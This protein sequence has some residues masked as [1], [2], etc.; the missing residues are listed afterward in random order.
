MKNLKIFK[1]NHKLLKRIG[2]ITLLSFVALLLLKY[3]GTLKRFEGFNNDIKITYVPNKAYNNLTQGDEVDCNPTKPSINSTRSFC[4]IKDDRDNYM[5]LKLDENKNIVNLKLQGRH[6]YNTNQWLKKVKI[7]IKGE[8]GVYET[9]HESVDANN[10]TTTVVSIPINKVGSAIRIYPVEYNIH[11]SA[12]FGLDVENVSNK[13]SEEE[14]KS[15]FSKILTNKYFWIV[16]VI[17]GGI[18]IMGGTKLLTNDVL[19]MDQM[20]ME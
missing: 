2:V 12:R 13:K 10:D 5:E 4:Y 14:E 17:I 19:P 16:I 1:K 18:S 9:V 3:T 8:S 20:L 15:M 7:T 6:E 11:P